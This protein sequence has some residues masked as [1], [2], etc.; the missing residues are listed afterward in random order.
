MVLSGIAALICLAVVLTLD[1]TRSST[2]PNLLPLLVLGVPT[3]IAGQ[4]WVIAV[5]NARKYPDGH[6]TRRSLFQARANNLQLMSLAPWWVPVTAGAAILIGWASFLFGFARAAHAAPDP[7]G[8][9]LFFYAF[10]WGI[11]ASEHYRRKGGSG[12]GGSDSRLS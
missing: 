10:H 4:L 2:Y 6:P 9:L 12:T 11:E 5:M 7:A 1:F 8:V 3:L